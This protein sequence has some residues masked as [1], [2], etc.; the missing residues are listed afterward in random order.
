[1]LASGGFGFLGTNLVEALMER[2]GS[3]LAVHVVDNLSTNP[4][5]Y[6]RFLDEIGHPRSLT[7]DIMGIHEFCRTTSTPTPLW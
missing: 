4:V 1:M 3:D 2:H 7:Y 6:D 5:P